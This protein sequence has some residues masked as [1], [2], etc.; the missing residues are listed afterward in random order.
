MIDVHCHLVYDVDDGS[1]NI[2][3]T[4]LMLKEAKQAGFSHIILTPHYREEYFTVP[5][6]EIAKKIE[7]MKEQADELGIHLYQGNEIYIT[8]EIV[9]LL[10]AGQAMTLN[11]SRYVLFELSMREKPI[12]AEQ[13]IYSILQAG[14]VP[15]MAHPERYPYVQKN[16]NLLLDYIEMGVLFQS[17][18][19]SIIGQY[20]KEVKDTVKILLTH[21][22]IH[23]LGSDNHRINSV[24]C[25]VDESLEQLKKLIGSEKIQELTDTN[26]KAIIDN[27]SI[28]VTEPREVKK[29]IFGFK[30]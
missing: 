21:N 27:Q 1:K 9:Q 29:G 18:Y 20:G 6:N 11:N 13:V 28:E 3:E 25:H 19:G 12:N 8:D 26:P 5:C 24:Y 15:I 4:N 23:F 22:M 16:P 17:N 10:Q 2:G 30:K 7:K 14:K